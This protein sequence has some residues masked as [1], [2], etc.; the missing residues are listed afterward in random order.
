[1]SGPVCLQSRWGDIKNQ[2][3]SANHRRCPEWSL[4]SPM[5]W[6]LSRKRLQPIWPEPRWTSKL[7]R[8]AERTSKENNKKAQRCTKH[9]GRISFG[10]LATTEKLSYTGSLYL[11]C[12]PC[13]P[14]LEPK[15]SHKAV[16]LRC[17]IS[18]ISITVSPT[19][20][21]RCGLLHCIMPYFKLTGELLDRSLKLSQ[22]V[23]SEDR[24]KKTLWLAIIAMPWNVRSPI[25]WRFNVLCVNCRRPSQK[26]FD[27]SHLTGAP[28]R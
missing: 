4:G 7:Q 11:A 23:D 14:D 2:P 21:K 5:T 8:N 10:L 6:T 18:Y 28:Q 3:W 15:S 26:I 9:I 13:L 22:H 1:M 25:V 27:G 12:H 17:V 16:K 20:L 24:K 19:E